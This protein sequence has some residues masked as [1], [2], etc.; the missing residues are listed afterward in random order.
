MSR[1]P[2]PFD[3]V[4]NTN[5][6]TVRVRGP[7]DLIAFVPFRLGYQP[8]ESVVVVSLRGPRQIVGLVARLDLDAYDGR[9]ADGSPAARA[10]AGSLA[11]IATKD[12]ADRAVVV[13][14]T[15]TALPAAIGEGARLRRAVEATVA[16]VE[17]RLPGT[18]AWVVTP[19]GYRALDCPDPLCCPPDGRPVDDIAHSRVA[20]SMVLAGRSVAPSRAER[21]HIPRASPQARRSAGRAAGRWERARATAAGWPERS[22]EEWRAAVRRTSA[23]E[24]GDHLDLAPATLG[25]LA[26]ALGDRGIRDALLLWLTAE[27]SATEAGFPDAGFSDAGFSGGGLPDGGLPAPGFSEGF[28]GTGGSGEERPGGDPVLRTAQGRADAATDAA[29]AR[30]M[31][32]IVDPEGATRP[33][34]DRVDPAVR[35]LE[36]VVSHAPRARQ[37]A[38][39]TLLG[40]VAWWGGDGAMAS[41]RLAAALAVDE[42]YTLAT[43][44]STALEA[45][46]PP[47][48]VR[49]ETADLRRERAREQD[50]DDGGAGEASGNRPGGVARPVFG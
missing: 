38:P 15:G 29:A 42:G 35:V 8:S 11:R 31:A 34:A 43:L 21:L 7:Q 45:G 22:L 40:L 50:L 39:L 32:R 36:A 14:Y 16:Q 47:G 46:L 23:A 44:V 24:P 37:P 48:W 18:E 2:G 25:R 27:P 13:G 3:G 9:A 49:R 12:G 17:R 41:G 30:A 4:M 19:G 1:C 6:I 26:A 28:S 20:A 10:A 33:W 5:A